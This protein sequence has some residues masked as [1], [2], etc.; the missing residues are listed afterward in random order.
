MERH[1][2]HACGHQQSHYLPGFAGEQD[3]KARWLARTK[4]KVC[5]I[6]T[7][8]AT[9][10]AAATE[11]SL[12]LAPLCLPELSGSD[13]QVSW[14]TSIRSLRLG[15]MVA[16]LIADDASHGSAWFRVAD[17][18]WWIDNRDVAGADLPTRAATHMLVA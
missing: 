10:A 2:T 14:A 6:A 4:C 3:S 17:A 8:R 1:V 7:K 13:R 5:F 11:A 15:S 9:E 18:K 12:A 16:D